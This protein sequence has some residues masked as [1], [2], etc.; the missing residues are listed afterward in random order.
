MQL[1]KPIGLHHQSLED[2]ELNAVSGG[3][4]TAP[5]STQQLMQMMQQ[6]LASLQ[7]TTPSHT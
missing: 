4:P 3:R 1:Q 5:Q 7:G 2:S 6:V